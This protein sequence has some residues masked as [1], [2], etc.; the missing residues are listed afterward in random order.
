[1]INKNASGG[2]RGQDVKNID[3]ISALYQE[4][5]SLNNAPPLSP[6]LYSE[7]GVCRGI[8]IFFIFAPCYIGQ[9]T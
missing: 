4:N 1:M 6:L 5:I 2:P 3:L 7:I 8:P 9:L